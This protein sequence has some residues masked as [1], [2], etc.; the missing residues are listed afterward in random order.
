MLDFISF[1]YTLLIRLGV[2]VIL[3]GIIGME[4]GGKNHD[5]GLRT[6]IIVC[7]GSA[8]IMVLSECLVT[9][10]GTPTEMMRM[11]AQVI[12]GI[13]FLGVGS[14]IV[15]GNR[16]RG[17]TTAAGLWTTA[18]VGLVVGSGYYILAAIIVLF[19]LF[20]MLGLR[21]L[22][23]YLRRKSE[24]INLRVELFDTNNLKAILGKLC[25]EDVQIASIKMNEDDDTAEI[26]LDI[27][28][29]GKNTYSKLLY[30]L[31]SLDGVNEIAVI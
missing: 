2:A 22:T 28:R 9:Q 1:D 27:K 17:I 18:C 31:S 4:R 10:Y 21:S 14:I 11:G 19:M 20:A 24:V 16:I 6:H 8:S 25:Q 26:I 5:A 23:S 13:G 12:S 29:T 30:D 3:G 7:L 15:D